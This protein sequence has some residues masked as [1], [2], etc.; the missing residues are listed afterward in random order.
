MICRPMGDRKSELICYTVFIEKAEGNMDKALYDCF[1]GKLD[2]ISRNIEPYLAYTKSVGDSFGGPSM[3]FHREAIKEAKNNFLGS[4]HLDMIYAVLPAWG[5]HKMGKTSVKIV[6]YEIFAKQIINHKEAFS[7][8]KTIDFLT[9]NHNKR[10][11]LISDVAKLILRIKVNEA[12]SQMVSSSKV[13]H[14]II[15]NLVC[16]IDRAY[17][18]NLLIGGKQYNNN[19]ENEYIEVIL[20]GMFDFIEKNADILRKNIDAHYNTSLTKIFDNLIIAYKQNSQ[21][22]LKA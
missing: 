14:H 11:T 20:T 2:E 3:Y 4:R 18:M 21:E 17:T 8:L 22:D 7:E 19:R 5:M 9:L 16:P 13:V 1:S 10:A 6:D 15:P 12:K